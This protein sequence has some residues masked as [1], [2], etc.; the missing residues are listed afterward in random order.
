MGTIV[1]VERYGT[2]GRSVDS[3]RVYLSVRYSNPD[4][5]VLGPWGNGG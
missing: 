4:R 1:A 2:G 3:G 5:V